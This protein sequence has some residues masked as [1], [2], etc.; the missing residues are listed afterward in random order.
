MEF[1]YQNDQRVTTV[2][3]LQQ[4]AKTFED[5]RIYNIVS[6]IRTPS[7]DSYK[8][9]DPDALSSVIIVEQSIIP[10]SKIK[11]KIIQLLADRIQVYA[12]K[13]YK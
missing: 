5:P 9:L 8:L 2:T 12:T 3:A 11:E 6:Q 4:A 1:M 7:G 10:V 13:D